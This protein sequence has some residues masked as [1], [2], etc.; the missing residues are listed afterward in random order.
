MSAKEQYDSSSESKNYWL[1]Q[2]E[3]IES[4]LKTLDA[5]KLPSTQSKLSKL[6]DNLKLMYIELNRRSQSIED[7]TKPI[8]NQNK[9]LLLELKEMQENYEIAK[10]KLEVYT[11]TYESAGTAFYQ[12]L[13]YSVSTLCEFLEEKVKRVNSG[14]EAEIYEFTSLVDLNL[15][16]DNSSR[17]SLTSLLTNILALRSSSYRLSPSKYQSWEDC[18]QKTI[19]RLTN[20]IV[21]LRKQLKSGHEDK[22]LIQ[23]FLKE[24]TDLSLSDVKSV[25]YDLEDLLQYESM[26]S[27]RKV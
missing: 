18:Y 12:E 13:S 20:E 27:V 15:P 17:S 8:I 19:Q 16:L 25:N 22:T 10:T 4:E 5:N 7:K 1:L 26:A 24:E 2:L 3:S 11:A 14:H 23:S 6:C 9:S 21:L